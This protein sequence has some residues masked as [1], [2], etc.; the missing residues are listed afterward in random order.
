MFA[1]FNMQG[2][3]VGLYL[4]NLLSGPAEVMVQLPSQHRR[5]PEPFRVLRT[6][7]RQQ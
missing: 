6:G 2:L 5:P 1:A 3:P 7:P 4:G